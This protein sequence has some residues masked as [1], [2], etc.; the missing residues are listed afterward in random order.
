MYMQMC[1]DGL[2]GGMKSSTAY[3]DTYV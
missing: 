3:T 1:G 2:M